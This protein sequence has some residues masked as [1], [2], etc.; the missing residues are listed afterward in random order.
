MVGYKPNSSQIQTKQIKVQV[1][2]GAIG[3]RMDEGF[4]GLGRELLR[5]KIKI[6]KRGE[7]ERKGKGK[8]KLINFKN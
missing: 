8:G 2:I 3:K 7:R 1:G 6:D 5:K 4:K